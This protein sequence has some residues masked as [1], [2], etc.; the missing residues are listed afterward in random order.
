MTADTRPP[1]GIPRRVLVADDDARVRRAVCALIRSA[2]GLS[3]VAEVSS[4]P[5]TLRA[6]EELAPD[7]VLLDVLLP[8][9]AE[10]LEVLDA[11]VARGRAVVALSIRGGLQATTLA[12]GA[13]AFVEKYAGPDALLEVLR[14]VPVVLPGPG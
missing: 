4:G 12:A 2:P 3:V 5:A 9:L 1:S 6:D 7:V 10:G 14:D 8:S 11:L 13:R